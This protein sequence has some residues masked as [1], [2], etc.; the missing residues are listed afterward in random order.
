MRP[1]T[2]AFVSMG[3]VMLLG[4]PVNGLGQEGTD[5]TS[6]E[7]T[8][9]PTAAAGQ[10]TI[11]AANEGTVANANGGEVNPAVAVESPD[12]AVSDAVGEG[13]ELLPPEE[14]PPL[15]TEA[16]GAV[17]AVSDPVGEGPELLPPEQ[18]PP[19][20]TDAAVAAVPDPIQAEV[21]VSAPVSS[22]IE[23]P[24]VVQ[25]PAAPSS[26]RSAVI[27]RGVVAIGTDDVV[28]R[29]VRYQADKSARSPVAER[30]L[31]FI[32]ALE[33]PLLLVDPASG[34]RTPLAPGQAAFIPA[35][36]GQQRTSPFETSV[37]YLAIELVPAASADEV[38]NG[39]VLDV[40][41]PFVPARDRRAMVLAR[42]ELPATRALA[43]PDTGEHNVLTVIQGAVLVRSS[44]GSRGLSLVANES[45]AFRGA[46]DVV[47]ANP[48]GIE[49]S[50]Q[51]SAI[52]LIASMGAA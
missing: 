43:V 47:A 34:E 45:V 20:A 31:G 42:H 8:L 22:A 25:A 28:W 10:V 36:A 2:I 33:D 39:D 44:D 6:V 41:E 14:Q 35:N 32:V 1:S 52:I 3:L 29:T 23:A 49:G 50:G 4:S 38:V 46:R 40:S 11:S 19:S 51:N 15:L 26:S 18:Q 16:P 21:P 37:H 9:A 30:A 12:P 24:V 13:P 27:A 17:V 7:I 5:S 48:E